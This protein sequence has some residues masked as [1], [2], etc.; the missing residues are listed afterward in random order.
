MA[1]T[2]STAPINITDDGYTD[3]CSLKCLF[4]YDYPKVDSTTFNNQGNYLGLSYPKAKVSYNNDDLQIDGIRFYSPSLHKFNGERAAGEIVI[5]HM[6]MGISLLVCI[7]ITVSSAKTDASKSLEYIVTQA[8]NRT[9]NVGET[10]VVALKN[11]SLNSFIPKKAPFYSYKGTLP[12]APCNG[13][14]QYIVFMPEV[15]P[16]HLSSKSMG[17]VKKFI[18]DHDSSIKPSTEYFYNVRG[19]IFSN[20]EEGDDD[21]YIECNPTGADGKLLGVPANGKEVEKPAIDFSHPAVIVIL[22]ILGGLLLI[23]VI[24][25]GTKLFASWRAGRQAGT[26]GTAGINE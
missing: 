20:I 8:M 11:F 5:S 17:I 24:S 15:T 4:K 23:L 7:P 26:A 14:H 13:T 16:L 25:M 19:A 22:G 6:D 9:P 18:L 10:A 12:Y 2:S 1:C 3:D 21:I